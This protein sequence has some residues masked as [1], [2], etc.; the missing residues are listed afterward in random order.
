MLKV[1]FYIFIWTIISLIFGVL[2]IC[3]LSGVTPWW[4]S[5]PDELTCPELPTPDSLRSSW[6][7]YNIISKKVYR[8]DFVMFFLPVVPSR[9]EVSCETPTSPPQSEPASVPAP[10][11]TPTPT[12]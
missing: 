11:S 2:I 7:K 9:K 6:Y 1:L 3:E 5:V 4:V 12:T 10:T 8:Y